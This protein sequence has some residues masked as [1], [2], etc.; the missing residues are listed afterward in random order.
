M[1]LL[2]KTA[3]ITGGSSPIGRVIVEEFL[4]E[5]AD[6]VFTYFVNKQIADLLVHKAKLYKRKC[7]ALNCNVKDIGK[8]EDIVKKTLDDF[9]K[10]DIL[11]NNVGAVFNGPFEQTTED[12]WNNIINTNLKGA[13]YFCKFVS[14]VMKKQQYGKIINISSIAGIRGTIHQTSYGAAKSGLIGFTRS[15]AMELAPYKINVNAIAPGVIE[16]RPIEKY[17]DIVKLIPIKRIGKPMDIA[18]AAVFLSSSD[19]DFIVGQT[20]VV[21]GGHSNIVLYKTNL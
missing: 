20:L 19:S 9:K 5:G 21:D 6:V 17:D 11:I 7:I 1:K 13:F 8:V 15:L 14:P 12:I 16:N 4:K 10:V 18:R 3:I 2:D